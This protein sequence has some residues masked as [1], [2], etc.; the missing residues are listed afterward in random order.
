L[1]NRI[2]GCTEW[3]QSGFITSEYLVWFQIVFSTEA[4]YDLHK[5]ADLRGSVQWR[6]LGAAGFGALRKFMAANR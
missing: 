4:R 1:F 6:K 2:C 5:F 3:L